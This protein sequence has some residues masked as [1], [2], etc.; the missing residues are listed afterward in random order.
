M[1][2]RILF[3]V[4]LV[5]LLVCAVASYAGDARYVKIKKGFANVYEFLDPKSKIV[6]QVKKGDYLEL[7]YEGTSWYQVKVKDQL[8][9]CEKRAGSVVD[10]P[11]VTVFSIPIGTFVLFILLLL[12][13]FAGASFFIYRQKTAEL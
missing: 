4:T 2:F 3:T 5:Y 7:V 9:W 10:N 1:K 8:G 13:T 11:G 12:G 6:K